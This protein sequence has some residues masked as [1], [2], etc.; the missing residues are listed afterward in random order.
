MAVCISIQKE[1]IERMKQE[2]QDYPLN[3]PYLLPPVEYYDDR[4]IFSIFLKLAIIF[5]PHK[6]YPILDEI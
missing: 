3:K 1:W 5:V 2:I 6:Q 4:P